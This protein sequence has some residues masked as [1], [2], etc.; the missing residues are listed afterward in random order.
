MPGLGLELYVAMLALEELYDSI[1]GLGGGSRGFEEFFRIP[2]LEV[3]LIVVT[4]GT[5]RA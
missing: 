1:P 3:V 4:P 2:G 5:P